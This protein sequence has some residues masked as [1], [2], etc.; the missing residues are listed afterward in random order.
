MSMYHIKKYCFNHIHIFILIFFLKFKIFVA[1]YVTLKT[2]NP[3]MPAIY[4]YRGAGESERSTFIKK[5][6]KWENVL[7]NIN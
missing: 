7:K 5:T 2:S 3:L 6:T 1:W 4:V